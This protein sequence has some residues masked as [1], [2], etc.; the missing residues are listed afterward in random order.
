MDLA[1]FVQQIPWRLDEACIPSF[2][3]KASLDELLAVCIQWLTSIMPACIR[4]TSGFGF[5]VAVLPMERF[6]ADS[7]C[8]MQYLQLYTM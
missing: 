5:W 6:T 3:K 1:I 8:G 7:R 4:N 2:G